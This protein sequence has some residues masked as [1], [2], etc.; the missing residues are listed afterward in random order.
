MAF[1]RAHLGLPFGIPLLRYSVLFTVESF[2]LLYLF[3]ILIYMFS[4]RCC[5]YKL[6]VF[7]ANQISMCEPLL[8]FT[9]YGIGGCSKQT[10][11]AITTQIESSIC[12]LVDFN[13]IMLHNILSNINVCNQILF[14]ETVSYSKAILTFNLHMQMFIQYITFCF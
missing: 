2:S 6:G 13:F 10:I 4:R 14:K 1:C 9:K 12:K 3:Y 11:Y 8:T 5:N 7:H